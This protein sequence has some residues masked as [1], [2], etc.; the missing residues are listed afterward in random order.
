MNKQLIKARSRLV[1]DHP[2]FGSLALRLRFVEDTSVD[3]AYTDGQVIGY[4]PAFIK[5]LDLAQTQF[6]IA[7]EV[8][9]VACL[10]HTRRGKRDKE[11]WNVAADY[12]INGILEEAGFRQ[13]QGAL[14]NPCFSDK[15]AEAIYGLL[16]ENPSNVDDGKYGQVRDTPSG[17]I[18]QTE[19]VG[20]VQL[21]QAAQQAKS[22]GNLP[23][24][25]TR[26]VQE[27]LYPS[28]DW[29]E[30]LRY[31]LE[32]AA[33]ND[34]SWMCPSRR[35]LHLGLHLPGFYTKEL[36]PVV[37]AVDTSGS[38]DTDA[39]NR[40]VSEISGVLE[41]FDT[42]IDVL[43]CDRE[44]QDHQQYD[45]QDLPLQIEPK[46]GGGTDFRPVFEW[47]ENQGVNPCCLIYL[48]DLECNRF[49]D[50]VP[51]YPVLWI[52]TGNNG[53]PVPFGEIV[54]MK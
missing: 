49:P 28:L 1:L 25:I 50:D 16:P 32:K 46:G 19:A 20:R 2:F 10:H 21:A 48:T 43:C 9:H 44:V 53:Y 18:K 27:M 14:L 38:I 34:F 3:T 26:L 37:I 51:A 23:G 47:V 54:Q 41:A 33:S 40:F 30:L 29:R 35:Y 42:L 36:G 39:L 31:F 45:R 4:N 6:L 52:Q 11:R 7:H 17:D 22:M 5:T 13:P 12:A 24:G 15:S 8:M